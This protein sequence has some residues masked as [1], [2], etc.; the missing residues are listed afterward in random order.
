MINEGQLEKTM[1]QSLD[2]I[3]VK[4]QETRLVQTPPQHMEP[5]K[6]KEE[7]YKLRSKMEQAVWQE[8]SLTSDIVVQISGKLDRKI[9]EYMRIQ[10]QKS[11]K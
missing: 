8:H 2:Q 3:D 11:M 7:I 5:D 10:Q 1:Q 6:L 9:N 4:V